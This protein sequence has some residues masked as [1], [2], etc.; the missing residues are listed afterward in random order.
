MFT[1]L[2]AA[3]EA[4]FVDVA[5]LL[6]TKRSADGRDPNDVLSAVYAMGFIPV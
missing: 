5:N 2:H 3:C 4:G 1:A 6:L